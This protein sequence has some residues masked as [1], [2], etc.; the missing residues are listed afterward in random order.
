[1][2]DFSLI[3]EGHELIPG[4]TEE[5]VIEKWGDPITG[6]KLPKDLRVEGEKISIDHAVN[7]SIFGHKDTLI[8]WKKEGI[9][10]VW[11][12]KYTVVGNLIFVDILGFKDGILLRLKISGLSW[13]KQRKSVEMSK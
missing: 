9:D 2:D 5:E 13:Y 4:M 10:T 7:E 8:E 3:V 1:M 6:S 11:A 12:Y